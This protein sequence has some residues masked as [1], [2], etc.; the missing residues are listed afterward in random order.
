MISLMGIG[1]IVL[2]IRH[3]SAPL[4][5]ISGYVKE[6]MAHWHMRHV[7]N[8]NE[9]GTNVRAPNL[10]LDKAEPRGASSRCV[11]HKLPHFFLRNAGGQLAHDDLSPI[12]RV[13]FL[14]P[15]ATLRIVSSSQRPVMLHSSYSSRCITPSCLRMHVSKYPHHRVSGLAL[16][17]L[18]P[19]SRPTRQG[20]FA[21]LTARLEICICQKH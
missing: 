17:H 6:D 8:Q 10:A 5:A 1:E 14:A 19:P 18:N 9:L 21:N 15:E 2:P 20:R 16:N 11:L 13:L 7:L 4:D 12:H 3:P